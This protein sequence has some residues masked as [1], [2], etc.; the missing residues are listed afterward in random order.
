MGD[1]NPPHY[2]ATQCT[3]VCVGNFDSAKRRKIVDSLT[4]DNDADICMS[5]SESLSDD[6]R[7]G[8]EACYSGAHSVDASSDEDGPESDKARIDQTSCEEARIATCEYCP[9]KRDNHKYGGLATRC[10]ASCAE[11]KHPEWHQARI[12]E[13]R[14]ALC[15]QKRECHK[16][17]GL[18]T[19]CCASCAEQ[20]HPEWHQARI[21]EPRCALCPQ[22]RANQR[23]GGLTTLCCVSCA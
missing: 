1:V 23:Y 9:R 4:A 6:S 8:D 3:E 15:P 13:T 18:T 11:Q 17:G 21:A 16:Y 20:K 10:C 19:L 2:Q 7:D 5:E 22:Q 14:C 12:A